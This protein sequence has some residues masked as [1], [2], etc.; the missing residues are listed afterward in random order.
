MAK[1]QKTRTP[2]NNDDQAAEQKPARSVM[3]EVASR[4][5]SSEEASAQVV[6]DLEEPAV[7]ADPEPEEP[8]AAEPE[9]MHR[10]MRIPMEAIEVPTFRLHL[11]I[12]IQGEQAAML[13]RVASALD[14]NRATLENGRR[15]TGTNDAV[16]WFLEQL[17]KPET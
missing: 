16:R 4:V 11:D 13:R 14:R 15:C 6:E 12:S 17:A 9:L 1:T 5:G 3:D 10:E 2:R 8:P 7:V